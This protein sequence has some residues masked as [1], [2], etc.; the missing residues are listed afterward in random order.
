MST[1]RYPASNLIDPVCSKLLMIIRKPWPLK[2]PPVGFKAY[3]SEKNELIYFFEYT[4]FVSND[5]ENFSILESKPIGEYITHKMQLFRPKEIIASENN[6]PKLPP[7]KLDIYEKI[8]FT[9]TSLFLLAS[10][11]MLFEFFNLYMSPHNKE[12]GSM[13]RTAFDVFYSLIFILILILIIF[14]YKYSVKE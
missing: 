7:I 9:L 5:S 14:W 11:V 13:V 4:I 1:F 12:H 10:L 2:L 3:H 8:I 6:H